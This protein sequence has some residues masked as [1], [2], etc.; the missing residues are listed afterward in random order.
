[1]KN[2]TMKILVNPRTKVSAGATIF[3]LL[4]LI[5]CPVSTSIAATV[6]YP[7]AFSAGWNLVGNSLTMPIDVKS[8]FGALAGIQTVWKWEAA[9]SRWALYAPALDKAGTLTSY[10]AVKGYGVLATISQGEGF[11]VNSAAAA[12]SE[13]RSG[14]GFSLQAANLA[15]GWNLSATADAVGAGSLAANLGNVTSVWAWDNATNAWYFHSPALT[16]DNLAKYIQ[17]KA[18]IDFGTLTLEGGRGFWIYYAGPTKPA[19]PVGSILQPPNTQ[20]RL[21]A[22]NCFQCHGTLGLGGFE[23]IRGKAD[24]V[25]EFLNKSARSNIMAAHAQGFTAAQLDAIVTYLNQ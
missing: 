11:W 7:Q 1:M 9:G 20:G 4:G 17:D 10:A 12:V 13:T 14:P 15:L 22:S 21:L 19:T 2:M 23:K 16:S 5:L 6:T 8:T 24:E 18:Y 25:R 3:G